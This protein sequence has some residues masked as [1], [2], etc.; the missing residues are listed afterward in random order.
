MGRRRRLR[1]IALRHAT[2]RRNNTV[3]RFLRGDWQ[4]RI[5]TSGRVIPEYSK[6]FTC[7][8]IE[9]GAEQWGG[10]PIPL[11]RIHATA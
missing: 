5:L 9:F 4:M 3:Q 10:A 1:D 6:F 7:A 11:G 8:R 2:V